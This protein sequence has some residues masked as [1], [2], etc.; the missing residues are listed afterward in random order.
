MNSR[1]VQSSIILRLV[2]LGQHQCWARLARL[3][4]LAKPPEGEPEIAQ[5]GAW[6]STHLKVAGC[7]SFLSSTPRLWINLGH[8]CQELH[9]RLHTSGT[10]ITNVFI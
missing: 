1:L 7:A 9:V 6:A 4:G 5:S 10:Y 8:L 3:C 2:Q